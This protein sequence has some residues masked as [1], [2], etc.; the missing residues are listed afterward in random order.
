M[1]TASAGNFSKKISGIIWDTVNYEVEVLFYLTQYCNLKCRGC[2]MHSSPRTSRNILPRDDMQFY[3]NEDARGRLVYC[4]Y[5]D[6][7]AGFDCNYLESVGRVPYRDKNGQC[8][9]LAQL[10]RDIYEKLVS[11]YVRATR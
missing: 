9:P 10:Q 7:T 2:Y 4:F 5:P 1:D 11:D 6:G 8:K 3:L